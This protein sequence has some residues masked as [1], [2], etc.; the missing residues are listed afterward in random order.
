M[1]KTTPATQ[2]LD[3]RAVKYSLHSYDYDPAADNIGMQA[4]AALG[5]SPS[6][7]LKTLLIL[8]DGHP[9]CAVLPSDSELS[10]KKAAAALGG[11]SAEMMKPANAERMTGF[12][13]GG[14]SPFGQKR[15]VPTLL[16]ERALTLEHVF[17]N[18]GQRGLQI[19]L[20]PKQIVCI[21]DAKAV[22]LIASA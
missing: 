19:R 11:K 2:M 10:M 1:S 14:I 9:T 15:N 21:L 6:V 16:E 8:V 18:G 5:V 22:P 13:I 7:V 12:K 4:A 17:V 20:D 3:I